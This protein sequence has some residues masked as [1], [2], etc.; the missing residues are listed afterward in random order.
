MLFQNEEV[1]SYFYKVSKFKRIYFYTNANFFENHI[2]TV[3]NK[4]GFIP[5]MEYQRVAW[6]GKGNW[7][8]SA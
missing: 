2:L 1:L 6:R 7:Q 4:I 5:N 8:N 3:S